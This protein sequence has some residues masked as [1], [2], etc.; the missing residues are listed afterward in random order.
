MA[1]IAMREIRAGE[2]PLDGGT[3]IQE[4]ADRPVFQGNGPDDYICVGCGN[5][6]AASMNAVQMTKKVR[7]R[8]GRC[9]TVNVSVIDGYEA[10]AR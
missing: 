2:V 8:C 1:T 4:D 3:A 6:L 10:P 5:V 7:V 9:S